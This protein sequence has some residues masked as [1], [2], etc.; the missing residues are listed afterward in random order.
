MIAAAQIVVAW[1]TNIYKLIGLGMF[2]EN[3]Y[4]KTRCLIGWV[5]GIKSQKPP[6]TTLRNK[7]DRYPELV[8]KCRW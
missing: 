7:W 6:D 8:E 5:I 4:Y 2:A 1:I 3:I